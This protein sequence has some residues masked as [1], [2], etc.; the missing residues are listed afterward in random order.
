M[1]NELKMLEEK[2]N[3][4]FKD[5]QKLIVALTHKSYAYEYSNEAMTEYNERIEFLGDAILEHVISDYLYSNKENFSEGKMSKLRAAIVCE[6]SLSK[7][8]KSISAEEFIRLGKCEKKTDGKHK[9][10]IIADAFEAIIG[11]VY[12]DGGYEAAKSVIFR[13][14]DKQI[15]EILSGKI[16]NM[17]Y[18]TALQEELQKNGTVKIE[19]NVLS[20]TGPEHD[21]NFF[22]EVLL[23]GKKIGEGYGKNKKQAEQGAAKDALSKQGWN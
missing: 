7:A 8:M 17:D 18:K 13:L 9:D 16:I 3:Y 12:L 5:I 20:E 22:I 23:N 15:E 4:K 6:A 10:A 14:L 11:A 19:Y 1:N 2:I 21:K